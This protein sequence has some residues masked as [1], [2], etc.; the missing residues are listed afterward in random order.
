MSQTGVFATPSVLFV[1]LLVTTLRI[2][3]LAWIHQFKVA[4]MNFFGL[5]DADLIK[6]DEEVTTSCTVDNWQRRIS[7]Y[8]AE[9][10][11]GTAADIA[12]AQVRRVSAGSAQNLVL[13]KVLSANNPHPHIHL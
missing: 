4:M 9:T 6:V 5:E 7:I 11:T 1:T 3:S 2:P 8:N 13:E 10:E 12:S